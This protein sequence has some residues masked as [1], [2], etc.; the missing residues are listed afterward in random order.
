MNHM[1]IKYN[2]TISNRFTG[3]IVYARQDSGTVED[4]S[5][6]CIDYLQAQLKEVARQRKLLGI[7]YSRRVVRRCVS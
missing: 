7:L 2:T 3:E 4:D 5:A 6:S 1:M